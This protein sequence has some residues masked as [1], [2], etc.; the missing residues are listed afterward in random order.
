MVG[1][2]ANCANPGEICQPTE[3][4]RTADGL[5][6]CSARPDKGAA[7]NGDLPCKPNLRCSETCVD[8]L[9]ANAP[10][11]ADDDCLTGYCNPFPPSGAGRT[12]LPGLSFAPFAPTCD[13]YFGPSST[14]APD[15]GTTAG[16]TRAVP[17][18]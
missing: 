5:S 4:C 7:C 8:K 18:P 3:Y 12:C 10:C 2:G 9:A 15:A 14:P 6:V 1:A 16:P 17:V 13:A 11:S